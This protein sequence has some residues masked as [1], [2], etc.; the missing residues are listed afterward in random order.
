MIN[1]I[2]KDAE[3]RMKKAVEATRSDFNTMRTG[4]AS[5]ALLD[6]V[7]VDYYGAPTPLNQVASVT[8]PDSQMIMIQPWDKAS[9]EA[10]EKAIQ[11]SDLGLNPSNDGQVIRLAI[12]SL[13]EERRVELQKIV[14][15]M[16]EEGRVAIRNIRRDANDHFKSSEKEHE[17]SEDDKRRSQDE[18]QGVTDRHIAEID[19]MLETKEKDLLEV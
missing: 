3:S 18:I 17:I 11:S 15:H 6:R 9:L 10:I 14:R 12:P 7:Q 2:V 13:T 4:R 8:V 5:P 16:A 19:H 1:K